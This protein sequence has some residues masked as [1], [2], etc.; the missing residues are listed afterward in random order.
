MHLVDLIR[1]IIRRR[2]PRAHTRVRGA[3]ITLKGA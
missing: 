2:Q 3:G 1:Q